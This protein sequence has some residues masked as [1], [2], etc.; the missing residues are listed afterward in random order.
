[1]ISR[2]TKIVKDRLPTTIGGA[3][4]APSIVELTATFDR[5]TG[6]SIKQSGGAVPCR[7]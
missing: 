6:M 2:A 4:K 7:V 5:E 1:M 3:T